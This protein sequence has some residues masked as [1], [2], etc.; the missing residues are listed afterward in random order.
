MRSSQTFFV[1]LLA[2][3]VLE[4][5]AQTIVLRAGNLVDPAT[6]TV[7]KNQTI[8][9]KGKDIAEIG[10][11]IEVPSGA[12]VIDLSNAWILPGLMDAHTHLLLTGYESR[13]GLEAVYV[14][15]SSGLR[16]LLGA[17]N[18]RAVLEAGF[19]TVKD[20]GNAANYGD[21]DLRR[22]IE[23]GWVVGPTMR[24]VGKI[25]A[26]FGGQ[27]RN[28]SPEQSLLWQ[29]EYIDADSPD[30]VRKA[31]RQNIFYGANAIK[32]VADNSRY[33]YSLEE[34]QAA[35]KEAHNAGYTVAVHAG[36]KEAARN[37]ILAG[38]ESIE[39]GTNLSDE[40]LRLMKEKGTFLVGTDFPEEHLKVMSPNSTRDQKAQAERIIDRLRR[41]HKIGVKMAFGSDVVIETFEGKNRGELMMDYLDVWLAAGIP[42]A[43][44]LKCWT[45]NPAELMQIESRRGN[46]KP[47]LAADIIATPGNP[48]QD[49]RALRKVFFVMKDGAVI[50]HNK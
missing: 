47:G 38:A 10:S 11:K 29:Y 5:H 33:Y 4:S 28:V 22:A 26:P 43:E 40:L 16:T 27:S 20:I 44:I 15:E 2:L 6:G 18:A 45:T 49:I 17:R 41:A 1:A 31:V 23:H 8:L 13:S 46:I 35:V 42:P 39:H 48:L 9:I 7:S 12:Q 50:K 3:F 34:I 19:T 37:A 14:K 32:L 30:E 21:V 24:T 36:G 25:I